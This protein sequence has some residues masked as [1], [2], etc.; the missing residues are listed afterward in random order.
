M[1]PGVQRLGRLLLLLLLLLLWPVGGGGGVLLAGVEE[2]LPAAVGQLLRAEAAVVGGAALALVPGLGLSAGT[3]AHGAG[4]VGAVVTHRTLAR[5][6][7]S[8]LGH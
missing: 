6:R 3:P 1:T 2:S 5:P 4:V 7:L 8:A